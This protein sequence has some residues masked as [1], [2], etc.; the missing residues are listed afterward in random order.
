MP[1]SQV[2]FMELGYEMYI[3]D[4]AALAQPCTQLRGALAPAS[5]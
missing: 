3:A 5:S 4:P 1:D 2:Y